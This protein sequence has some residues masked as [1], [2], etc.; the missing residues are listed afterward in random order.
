MYYY[1]E[2]PPW[3]RG[4]VRLSGD[5]AALRDM[6]KNLKGNFPLYISRDS[7][8]S[9]TVVS[10]MM[11][12][13]LTN[14]LYAPLD[15]WNELSVVVDTAPA[16]YC[17]RSI[18]LN[19]DTIEFEEGALPL[20][21]RYMEKEIDMFDMNMEGDLG[22]Y[23]DHLTVCHPDLPEPAILT[24]FALAAFILIKKKN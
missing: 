21:E 12:G 7:L 4:T 6:D 23:I 11:D 15:A 1:V 3:R 24:L 18:C 9:N 13:A 22:F 10:C 14:L 5:N 19:E 20:E 17:V 8:N 16:A 2:R